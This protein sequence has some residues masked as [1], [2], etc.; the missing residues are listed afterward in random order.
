MDTILLAIGAAIRRARDAAGISQEE[1][2]ALA[3]VHRTYIGG[4][5]RGERN[6]GIKNLVAIARALK[7]PPAEFLRDLGSATHKR[8]R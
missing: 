1:L 5:E 2:A 6:V 4:V 7:V 8:Q 3:G